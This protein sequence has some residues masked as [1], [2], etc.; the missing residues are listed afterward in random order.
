[1]GNQSRF[2]SAD[3]GTDDDTVRAIRGKQITGVQAVHE[4]VTWLPRM[5]THDATYRVALVQNAEGAGQIRQ[6]GG[7]RIPQG[8]YPDDARTHQ[9]RHHKY[10]FGTENGPIFV[11]PQSLA[12]G[13]VHSVFSRIIG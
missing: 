7:D 8:T 11:A 1:V 3:R 4:H 9:E 2:V 13:L 6:F 12:K 5:V 10:E